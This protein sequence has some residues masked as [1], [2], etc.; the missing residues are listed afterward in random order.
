MC[1]GVFKAQMLHYKN[2][3]QHFADILMV[4]NQ[5]KVKPT[6]QNHQ[7]GKQKDVAF[8]LTVD[9][10]KVLCTKKCSI[11]GPRETNKNETR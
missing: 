1:T 3:A 9:H 10:M 4:E 5:P 7:T 6:F 8:K 11:G 2:P